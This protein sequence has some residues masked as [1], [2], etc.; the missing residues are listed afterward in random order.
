MT[1]VGTVSTVDVSGI[2]EAIKVG[3]SAD[4]GISVVNSDTD[5]KA[6]ETTDSGSPVEIGSSVPCIKVKEDAAEPKAEVKGDN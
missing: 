4:A 1:C 2:M 3:K 5:S 6:D